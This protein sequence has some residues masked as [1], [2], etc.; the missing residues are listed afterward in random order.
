MRDPTCNVYL[1][2]DNGRPFYVGIGSLERSACR[3]HNLQAEGRR[4]A[5][6][7]N[8]CFKIDVVFTG[9]REN[10]QTIETDLIS[11]YGSVVSGGLLFNFTPGGDGLKGREYLSEAAILNMSEGGRKGGKNKRTSR[12]FYIAGG[13]AQGRRN[14]ESGHLARLSENNAKEWTLV[15]PKG[16]VIT[17]KNKAKFCRDN[18]LSPGNLGRVLRGERSHHKGYRRHEH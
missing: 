9:S 14:V 15:D 18:N 8:G 16:N 17:F 6:E 2:L 5:A 10:C 12:E 1:W 7:S 11:S 13:K 3:K 4:K